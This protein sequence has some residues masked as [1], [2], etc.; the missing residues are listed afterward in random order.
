L[1]MR[2]HLSIIANK[3]FANSEHV[4][5]DLLIFLKRQKI[6]GVIHGNSRQ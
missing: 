3:L 1:A 6:K 2:F 4:D 5:F